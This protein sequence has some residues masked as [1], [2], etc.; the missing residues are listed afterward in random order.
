M[1]LST[2]WCDAG[3]LREHLVRRFGFGLVYGMSYERYES[4]RKIAS[5][6]AVLAGRTT[7]G[8]LDDVRRDWLQEEETDA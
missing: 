6:A 1:K 5:R 4:A 2:I 8:V 7:E 3:L